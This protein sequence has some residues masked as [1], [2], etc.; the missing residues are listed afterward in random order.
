MICKI[1]FLLGSFGCGTT[2]IALV[3]SIDAS[4]RI[5]ELLLARKE[6]MTVRT[7]FHMKVFAQRRTRFE[8][9][10]TGTDHRDLVV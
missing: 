4:G 1:A 7:N 2:L 10:S 5:D 3:E 8:R 9:V 6:R